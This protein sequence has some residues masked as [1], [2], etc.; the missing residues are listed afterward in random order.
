MRRPRKSCILGQR[1]FSLF[2]ALTFLL[3]P[4]HC[5]ICILLPFGFHHLIHLNVPPAHPSGFYTFYKH[6]LKGLSQASNWH[7]YLLIHP[8]RKRHLLQSA[9]G[10]RQIKWDVWCHFSCAAWV[11]HLVLMLCFRATAS[12]WLSLCS[13]MVY[14][15][16]FANCQS[17][18]LTCCASK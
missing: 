4:S 11:L 5:L 12:R 17:Q 15:L 18:Y 8:K 9:H 7:H 14:G 3:L 6:L 1:S 13:Q 10:R 2:L 16:V